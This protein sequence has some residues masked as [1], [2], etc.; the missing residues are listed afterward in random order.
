MTQAGSPGRTTLDLVPVQGTVVGNRF[1]VGDVLATDAL[2]VVAAARD[3]KT[4]K[5]IFLRILR[6]ELTNDEITRSLRGDARIAAE[7]RHKAILATYGVGT[8]A[9]GATY[10]ATEAIDG[11]PLAA[12]VA[13]RKAEG[14]HIS[15]RGAFNVVVHVCKALASAQDKLCHGTLRPS[16][17]WI[18]KN[19][20]VKVGDFGVGRVLVGAHGATVLGPTEQACL[21]PEVKAGGAADTRSDIFGLGAIFYELLT[22][23]SPAEGFVP[24]SQAHP[25]ATPEIDSVLLRCLAPTPEGRFASPDEVRIALL[26]LVAHA[27]SVSAVQDF[28]LD[29][30]IDVDLGMV[31]PP[32]VPAIDAARASRPSG[33]GAVDRPK[34]G[35]RVSIDESF[36]ASQV[37]PLE[38]PVRASVVDLSSALGRITDKGTAHWMLQKDGLDHGP[39]SGREVVDQIARGEIL[40]EHRLQN[41]DTGERKAVSD[42]PDFAGFAEQYRK[43]HETNL[44]KEAVTHAAM[45]DVR[46][47]KRKLVI[48]GVALTAALG[49]GGFFLATR[50]AAEQRVSRDQE[51]TSLYDI[52]RIQASASGDILP[53]PGRSGARHAGGGRT[54]AAAGSSAGAQNAAGAPEGRAPA[55]AGEAAPAHASGGRGG[56]TFE[57]AMNQVVDFGDV[58][59]GGGNSSQLT[60]PQVAEVMNRHVGR[61]YSA[62]VP[63]EQARGGELG[64]VQIDIAIASDGHVMGA[65]SRQGSA[66]FRSCIGR[67]VSSVRFP[68]FGAPR[69]AARYSFDAS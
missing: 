1:E 36:R 2:G 5:A 16:V 31:V 32:T 44:H 13:R 14:G 12:I 69:M 6:P 4:D 3:T 10:V 68:E 26:P 62:C 41:M 37:E 54:G 48:A 65:S 33:A 46:S 64:R 27:P 66:E 40:L 22:G 11:E 8:T 61:I 51:V 29:V 20:R 63:A 59:R 50:D 24:P 47:S 49:A 23:R 19:G 52:R 45:A 55:E 18:G 67:Q 39:F 28:G 53:D 58:S 21:A 56:P 57:D 30:E 25:D 7:L 38:A 34:V 15:L 43:E 9:T 17:V 35:S 60:G 42:W